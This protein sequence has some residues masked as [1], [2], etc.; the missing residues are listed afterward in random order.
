MTESEWLE[1]TDSREMF[2][3]FGGVW[4][5]MRLDPRLRRFSVECCRRVRH[6][7]AEEAFR[8]A[9]AAGEAFADDPRNEKSTIPAMARAA[10]EGWRYLRH[11][12]AC[13][14]RHERRAA[15][16]A[17]ATCGPT[18]WDSAFNAMRYAAQALNRSAPDSCE[19]SELRHQA[20]LLRC[21]YGPLLDHRKFINPS[22]LTWN[23]RTI[24][25]IAQGIYDERRM[26]EGTLDTG[27]LAI[28]HDALLDAGCGNEELLTHLRSEGPHVRGCWPVDLIL[29]KE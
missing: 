13:A 17:I 1:C 28:L 12:K 24:P 19:S 27:R 18:A 2:R 25:R 23:D 15:H 22:W 16:A 20:A 10:L 21:I 26:P 6:L 11:W 5:K 8:V 7:L 29:G 9:A 14:S 4:G 3:V